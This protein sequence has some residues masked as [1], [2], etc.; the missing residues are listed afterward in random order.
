MIVRITGKLIHVDG[1][2]GIVDRDGICY[3][4][5]LPAFAASELTQ[6]TGKQITLHTLQ[7]YEGSAAGGNIYPRL[8]GFID[9][10]DRRFFIEFTKVKG[11]GV[12]KALRALAKPSSWIADVIE[13][14]DVKTLATLPEVGKRSAEQLVASLKGKLQEFA[15][16]STGSGETEIT[17]TQR[18]A[19]EI[20][21]QLGEKRTEAVE[22]IS[23]ACEHNKH[24]N[25]ADIVDTVYKIKAGLI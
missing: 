11:M 9:E 2:A 1:E 4:I 25:P 23:R 14:G 20:L 13:Q 12:K 18:E 7:Y 16:A 10:I 8:V 21:L 22:L 17:Q 24:D 19:L 5:Y 3:E 15:L 6:Y